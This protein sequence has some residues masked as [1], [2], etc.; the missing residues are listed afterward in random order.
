MIDELT[1]CGNLIVTTCWCG[2]RHAVPQELRDHQLRQHNN[3]Q[4]PRSI[5]CPLGHEH[6]PAGEGRAEQLEA[7]LARER[8]AHDQ[9]RAELR[10]TERRRR[11][12]KAAKMRIANR[13]KN[14]VCPCCHRTF[15]NLQR[16]MKTKHADWTENAQ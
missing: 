6:I 2:M 15:V 9:T 13:V 5:F 11:S 4:A 10:T 3:G 8:A 12:E 7:Q 16:H 1:Y 14:G